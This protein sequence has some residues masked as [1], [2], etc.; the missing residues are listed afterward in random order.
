VR[1]RDFLSDIEKQ[2][3]P[4]CLAVSHALLIST[5]LLSVT[6]KEKPDFRDMSA[7]PEAS[8]SILQ[9]EKGHWTIVKASSTEHLRELDAENA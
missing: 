2:S 6:G 8:I 5:A 4:T 7:I 3:N 9:N 1:V